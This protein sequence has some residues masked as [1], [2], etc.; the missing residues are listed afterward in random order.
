MNRKFNFNVIFKNNYIKLIISAKKNVM[1]MAT[2]V[3]MPLM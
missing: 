3:P 2:I 1:T